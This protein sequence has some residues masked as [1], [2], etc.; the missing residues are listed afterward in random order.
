MKKIQLIAPAT[1]VPNLQK[2]QLE[3]LKKEFQKMGY[4]LFYT[5]RI[6]EKK[7]F[8]CGSDNVRLKELEQAFCDPNTDAILAIRGGEG[9]MRLLDKLDYKKIKKHPKPFIGFS[10]TTALQNALW[11]KAKMPSYTGFV[12]TFGFPKISPKMFQNLKLCLNNQIRQ[13]PIKTIRSGKAKGTLLGGSLG[14]FC[15]LL[16]TPFFPDMKDNVLL[17]EE[18]AEPAYRLDRLFNQLHLSGVFDQISGLVL[19]DMTAGLKDQAKRLANQIIKEHLS[20][21]KCPIVSIPDY[22]HARK[23]TILPIGANVQIDTAKNILSLDKV[24]EFD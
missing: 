16:G 17:L 14:V 2:E 24:K 7:Y 13:I 21:L 6:F 15:A 9:S 3:S 5:P 19:G 18:V 8:L 4:D 20:V 22:S 11:T 1:F 10:D 12:G 23:G